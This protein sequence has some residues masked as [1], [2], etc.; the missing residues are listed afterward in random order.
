MTQCERTGS[1][2]TSG[3][4]LTPRCDIFDTVRVDWC[5]ALAAAGHKKIEKGYEIGWLTMLDMG[6]CGR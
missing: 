5:T 6:S 3:A 1:E 4:N 2:P